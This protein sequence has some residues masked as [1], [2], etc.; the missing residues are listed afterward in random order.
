MSEVKRFRVLM[1]LEEEKGGFVKWDDYANAVQKLECQVA[2]A[3]FK[4]DEARAE[5]EALRRL[6][7]GAGLTA[8]DI[9][10]TL[11]RNKAAKDGVPVLAADDPRQQSLPAIGFQNP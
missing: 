11:I 6:S 3:A 10:R 9:V 2:D 1:P 5:H 8:S 4:A 7:D